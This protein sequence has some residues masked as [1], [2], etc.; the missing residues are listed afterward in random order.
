MNLRI[1]RNLY[2]ELREWRARRVAVRHLTDLD[3][4]LLRDIGIERADIQ[5]YVDGSAFVNPREEAYHRL[6]RHPAESDRTPCVANGGLL[7]Q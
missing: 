6:V 3:D 4:Y 5:S 7:I 2:R 1:L